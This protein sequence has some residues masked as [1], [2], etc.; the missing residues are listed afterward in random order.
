MPKCPFTKENCFPACA[1]WNPGAKEC[2]VRLAAK[3]PGFGTLKD[4]MR[5]TYIKRMVGDESYHMAPIDFDVP[6]SEFIAEEGRDYAETR[7]DIPRFDTSCFYGAIIDSTTV[8]YRKPDGKLHQ[9]HDVDSLVLILDNAETGYGDACPNVYQR[10][11]LQMDLPVMLLPYDEETRPIEYHCLLRK[12]LPALKGLS[13]SVI[14]SGMAYLKPIAMF[15]PGVD[16]LT[17]QDIVSITEKK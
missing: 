10:K 1:I 6:M 11:M 12:K 3:L 16:R 14:I 9:V 5:K 7:G 4:F 8:V 2:E 15:A 17:R 13:A